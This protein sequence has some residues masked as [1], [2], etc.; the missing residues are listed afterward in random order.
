MNPESSARISCE[1][2][3][4]SEV[5]DRIEAALSDPAIDALYIEF[6]SRPETERFEVDQI[7]ADDPLIRS[8][9]Q[10]DSSD[11]ARSESPLLPL[12]PNPLADF[13]LKLPWH[14]MSDSRASERSPWIF[15][16]SNMG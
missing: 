9:A 2:P 15:P 4:D 14:V 10:P 3:L 1:R 5:A 12:Y 6:R 7:L 16:G 8:S 11:G 13:N